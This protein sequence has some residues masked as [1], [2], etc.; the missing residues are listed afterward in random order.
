MGNEHIYFS[1]FIPCK[2]AQKGNWCRERGIIITLPLYLIHFGAASFGDI[3]NHSSEASFCRL[4]AAKALI[5][6]IAE[7][8]LLN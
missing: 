5:S 4:P 8:W 6:A 1:Y 2:I 7:T 3:Y